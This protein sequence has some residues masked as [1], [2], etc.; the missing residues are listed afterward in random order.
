MINLS[1]LSGLTCHG[2]L[3]C[4]QVA[5]K[6]VSGRDHQLT[7]VRAPDPL[8]LQGVLII[9]RHAH[10]AHPRLTDQ[11]HAPPEVSGFQKSWEKA[12][13]TSLLH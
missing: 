10:L 11:H 7:D 2:Q 9:V 1:R 8:Q 12:T 13:F 5:A 6:L 3:K 4:A